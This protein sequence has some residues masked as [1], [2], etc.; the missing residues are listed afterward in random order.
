MWIEK[1]VYSPFVIFALPKPPISE[2]N[3]RRGTELH[4]QRIPGVLATCVGYTQGY[5]NKPNYEQVC[6]GT[7]QHTE[8]IQLLFDPEICS[9][10]RL[11]T[12]LF[13]TINPTLL[14]R[15]G[16]DSGTQYRHG[17]YYHTKEQQ[18]IAS[19]VFQSIQAKY[20][21]KEVVTELLPAKVFWPAENYH[22]RYLQK[23][24]QSAEKNCE[25]KVRCYG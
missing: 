3:V 7:T 4:Y 20:D 13:N 17:I 5:V 23:G 8:G 12:Q 14:N 2:L 24:G 6:S 15:V 10:E 18:D 16:N 21:P 9:Y 19:S 1:E 22:Q 11:V 25:E